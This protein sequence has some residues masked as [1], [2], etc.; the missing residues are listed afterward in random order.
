MP[1]SKSITVTFDPHTVIFNS[2]IARAVGV[3]EVSA[4]RWIHRRLIRRALPEP[5]FKLSLTQGQELSV[6]TEADGNRIINEYLRER[7]LRGM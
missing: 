4:R 1:Q 6:W 2:D 5:L 7:E 3:T